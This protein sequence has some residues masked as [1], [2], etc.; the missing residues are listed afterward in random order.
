MKRGIVLGLLLG[1]G[2][3]SLAIS[4]AQQPPAAG[5]QPPPPLKI[6]VEKLKENL[7]VLKGGGGNTAVFIGANGVVIVDTKNPGWGQLL[8][9]EIR[10]ITNKPVTTLINTHSHADHVSGNPDFPGTIEVVTHENTMS[11]MEAF[12][13]Y[14]GSFTPP[15]NVFKGSG[16]KGLPTRTFK[17]KMSVGSGS[18]QIDL[19]YFGRGHTN[20]DAWV[21]FP[22]LR[23][24]HAGDMFWRKETPFL[25]AN[26]GGSG[27]EF[28]DTLQKAHDTLTNVDTIIT[29]HGVQMTRADLAEFATFNR[30]FLNDVRAARQ[31]GK[32]VDDF[33]STWKQPAKYAGYA[34]PQPARLKANTQVIFDELGGRATPSSR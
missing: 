21:M 17:D 29:G 6:D 3:L 8:L 5:G 20:G 30:E 32:T 15:V 16:G 25:D 10:K 27:V 12:M 26:T 4:A 7:F 28:P 22:T 9:E 19:Y 24:L 23:V 2:A 33:A 11:N 14:S 34:T 1:V 31:A 13:A 18:D